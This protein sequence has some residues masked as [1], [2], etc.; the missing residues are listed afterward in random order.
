MQTNVETLLG[1]FSQIRRYYA[2]AL[3]QRLQNNT[4]SPSEISI[5][6][7]LSNNPSI[8]TG[9]QLTVL[10]GIS[11]GLV[12]RS[13]DALAQRGLVTITADPNDKRIR[14]LQLSKASA[15]LI[16][17]LKQEMQAIN[18]ELFEGIAEADIR[19]MEQ[20]MMQIIGRFKEQG[21]MKI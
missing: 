12:S 6:I 13:V 15:S 5:L 16:Q 21:G 17:E 2:N 4:L 7:L 14:Q 1:Y 9:T 18:A 3:N 10:L 19:H 11:K 8:T 20:T